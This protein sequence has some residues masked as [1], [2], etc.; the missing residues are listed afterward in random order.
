[1]WPTWPSIIPLG[2]TTC[3][4]GA[5]LG[6]RGPGVDLERGVVVDVAAIVEH[7][8]VAVVGV[9]VDAQVGDQHDVVAD[10]AA[11]VGERELH[12][13][14]RVEGAAADGVLRRRH[15]EQDHGAHAELGQLD[16]L[17]AQ[18]VAGVLHDARQRHDRLRLGDALAH[19][20]RRDEVGR[21]ARTSRRRRSRIAG[22]RRRRRGRAVGN[23]PAMSGLRVDHRRD[24]SDVID[25]V[26]ARM[27]TS[28][29]GSG[30]GATCATVKPRRRAAPAVTGPIVTTSGPL[31]A[32]RR[33]VARRS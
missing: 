25:S 21:C 17:L 6:H 1:M 7:A 11:Q 13:A 29:S 3:G 20:Q 33:G 2:A 32:D 23:D 4:A 22:V 27:R 18:A 28:V 10:V 19:E 30:D 31:E 16:D 14:V 8:A 26:V 24:H 12:D 9:L 15:T 5:G